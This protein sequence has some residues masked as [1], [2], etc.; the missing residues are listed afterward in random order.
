MFIVIYDPPA[1][2]DLVRFL[3]DHGCRAWKRTAFVIQIDRSPSEATVDRLL[4][5]WQERHEG[6]HAELLTQSRV[7]NLKPVRH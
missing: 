6:V 4:A 3:W 7:R 2:D 5:D 1:A